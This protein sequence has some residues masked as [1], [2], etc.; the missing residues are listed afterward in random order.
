M[1]RKRTGT[2]WE[3]SPG[4]WMIRVTLRDGSRH[5]ERIPPRP[6]GAP[7]T[8]EWALKCAHNRQHQCDEGEW[9]PQPKG[10]SLTTP[11]VAHTV[12]S[13]ATAWAKSLTIGT[14]ADVRY[15]IARYVEADPVGALLLRA[16]DAPDLAAWI[17]RLRATPSR[18]GGTLAPMSVGRYVGLLHQA[19]KAAMRAGLI[20]RDPFERL[21]SGIV[22]TARDKTPGARR[23]WRYEPAE[24]LALVTDDR[25]PVDR[26]MMYALAFLTGARAG[27]LAALRWSDWERD[28]RPLGRLHI[29]RT[30]V[31][32]RARGGE[33][34][35]G[36]VEKETKTGAV[37]E[38]PVHPALAAM[39]SAWWSS[40]WREH[41]GRD[42]EPGDL[43]VPTKD[44]RSRVA[45]TSWG[46]LQRDCDAL[47]IRRRRLH[48]M[49]HTMIRAARDAGADR[50]AV[51]GV[52]HA[53]SSRDAFDGYDRPGWDRVCR[54]LLK[55]ELSLPA[56]PAES[57]SA[58]DS[59]T[60][61]VERPT[62]P[63]RLR[64][65]PMVCAK[66]STRHTTARKRAEHRGWT[67]VEGARSGDSA[68]DSATSGALP[69]GAGML[70]A[71]AW[72]DRVLAAD[73]SA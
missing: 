14:A 34:D 27:E 62:N 59:A 19:L 12:G 24:I 46:L 69:W 42:P 53:G 57:D 21:P 47:G 2:A 60:A 16:L 33:G 68:P 5:T 45:I 3:K 54:E 40:G 29:A 51:R 56:P 25:V 71:L 18:F 11:R 13:W 4:V 38:A 17:A 55:V 9:T 30:S 61:S 64:P 65:M 49:R 10:T 28:A 35:W 7:I 26:R 39:L 48:G 72:G 22:P 23:G 50:E 15:A 63:R 8:R 20:D 67:R 73:A 44:G 70:A 6:S 36:R 31:Y 58:P 43:I 66:R 37:K 52:T 1:G 32:R 41:Q